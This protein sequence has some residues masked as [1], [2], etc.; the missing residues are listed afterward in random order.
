MT[1]SASNGDLKVNRSDEK[2]KNCTN[3]NRTIRNIYLKHV[4]EFDVF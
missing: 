3:T 4:L 2:I 1:S